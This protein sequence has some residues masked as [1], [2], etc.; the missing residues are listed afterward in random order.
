MAHAKVVRRSMSFVDFS[1]HV[2]EGVRECILLGRAPT[3]DWRVRHAQYEKDGSYTFDEDWRP[4]G[5]GE[6]WGRPDGCALF[7]GRAEVPAAFAGRAVSL[8]WP[9]AAEVILSVDGRL[10]DGV[11]PN[12]SLVPLLEE[13]A[14]DERLELS[15]EAYVRSKPDDERALATSALRGCVQRFNLP[16]LVTVD[17]E[18]RRAH[19]ELLVLHEAISS[20]ALGEDLRAFLEIRLQEALRLLPPFESSPGNIRAA[21]PEVRRYLAEEVYAGEASPFRGSG[22]LALVAHSHLDIAYF[23]RVHQTV[24]KNARTCL[25]QL[26]LMDR[27][28]G[29]RYAHTQAQTYETLKQHYPALFEEVRA[30]IAE[31][32]WEIVGA[33]YVEPDC[34]MISAESLVRQ[35]LYGRRFFEREFGVEVDNCWLP[36]V[37]GNSPIM[38]QV[39]KGCGVDYFVSNKMSTWNDTNR[40]PHNNFM[41]RGLDGT[42][43][44]A[45]VP[46]VHFI[47]WNDPGQLVESWEAFIDKDACDESLHMYGFGDGG[48]GA[49]DEMLERLPL[50]EKL[51]GMPRCRLT[52]GREYLHRA[53]ANPEGLARWDGELY[54]EM[55]RG[56]LTSKAVLKRENRRAEFRALETEA[57]AA[58]AAARCGAR[59]PREELEA[60]WKKLLVNQ[61]HDILPGSNTAPVTCDAL[62]TYARAREEFESLAAAAREALGH[63][64]GGGGERAGG[65]YRAFNALGFARSGVAELPADAAGAALQEECVAAAPGQ[66]HCRPVGFVSEAPALG[67]AGLAGEDSLPGGELSVAE[68]RLENSCLSLELNSSGELVSVLDKRTARQVLAA[69]ATG[70]QLQLF[71]DRPGNYNAWDILSSF[72]DHRHPIPPAESIDVVERGPLSVAVRVERPLGAGRIVQV[73]RLRRASARVDFETWVDWREREKLLKVA[74]PLAVHAP[75]Y[76]TDTSAGGYL[77]PNNRNTS[78]EQARFEVCCHKW[79]D[80][81]EGHYG[82]ALL[83]DCKYG[84]DVKGNV[85]RLSLLR[86]PIRPDPTSDEG[87]HRFT[88]SLLPHAGDWREGRVSEQAL[89]LNA[90]MRAWFAGAGCSE[91]RGAN[92]EISSPALHLQSLKCAE[93]DSGDLV[94]RLAEL[95]GSRGTARIRLVPGLEWKSVRRTD[96]LERS[97]TDGQLAGG[98]VE[99]DYRPYE[100]VTLRFAR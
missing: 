4:I 10:H 35:C 68:D 57:L 82:V 96:M 16:E 93:D 37:F 25:I 69:G 73:I 47:T 6:N 18:S 72:E 31:G 94:L 2:I 49:T 20:P 38:P 79:V 60:A 92:L 46:P 44:A 19:L 50:V 87:Q 13:A 27:H 65:R 30:R 63:A 33:P 85:L 95:H 97:L 45:C 77:R 9:I 70:N 64:G 59:Y 71:E 5:P 58:V 8:H 67:F 81:S 90:P 78:W 42:E 12:R 3:S 22:K 53:F 15:C 11:D 28:P 23:W 76:T 14:G 98:E 88:Y 32:R 61:F 80:L 99:A 74:F 84:C 51:P 100:I 1:R 34:N 24:Q 62:E 48:S 55:H 17:E 66:A 56:T 52:T 26:R 40:F 21:I 83:N 89:D 54:L 86:G 91:A 29:F 7:V 43:I 39:L 41:W 75:V 36:D